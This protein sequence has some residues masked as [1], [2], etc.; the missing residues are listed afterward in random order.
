MRQAQA[1]LICL[2]QRWLVRGQEVH[3]LVK[4]QKRAG[5]LPQADEKC[6]QQDR[7]CYLAGMTLE[8]LFAGKCRSILAHELMG[9]ISQHSLM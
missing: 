1:C 2:C 5:G 6:Q 9:D 7:S 4:V 8:V 3:G